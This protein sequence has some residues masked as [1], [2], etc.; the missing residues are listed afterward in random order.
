ME[1]LPLLQ[2]IGFYFF[3]AY[4]LYASLC[5]F[6]PLVAVVQEYKLWKPKGL[7]SMSIYGLI[8]VYVFNVLW[9]GFCL[10][11][12]TVL[13]PLWL[14]TGNVQRE[15][16]CVVERQVARICVASML[17]PVEVRGRE[18]LPPDTPGSPAPVYIANHA[19]QIDVAVVYYLWRQFKWI[20][21]SSVLMMPGVGQIMFLADH[22]FIKRQGKNKSSINQLYEKSNNAVQNGTP[23]FFFPQGTRRMHEKLE[24]KAG[25]F[26]VA[27]Q[28]KSCLVPVSIE[29]PLDAWNRLYPLSLLWGETSKPIILTVHKII[30]VTGDEDREALMKQCMDVIYSA[31]PPVPER[32]TKK[33][34]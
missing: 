30:Q 33:D 6:F 8:K 21:K 4:L 24:F 22:V 16:N 26:N 7:P 19:S 25:A 11:G 20:A 32:E 9:T 28:N 15:A 10:L 31:L 13:C 29:I 12:A 3:R 2:T 18:N 17:G 34:K 1:A 23:M 14:V 27:M 5:L